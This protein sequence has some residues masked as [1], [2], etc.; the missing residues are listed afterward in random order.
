MKKPFQKAVLF[1]LC[2]LGVPA[3]LANEMDGDVLLI[4]YAVSSPTI[5]GAIDGVWKNVC[6]TFMRSYGNSGTLPE[7]RID[8]TGAFR[9]MWDDNNFYFLAYTQDDVLYDNHD[10]VW[11]NDGWELYFDADNSKGTSYD[12]VDDMQIRIEHRDQ[13]SADIDAGSWANKDNFVFANVDTLNGYMLELQ[14]PLAELKIPGEWGGEFG[15]EVQQNDN[16]GADREH[17]SKWWLLEGDRSWLDPSLF[18]T[19]R[20]VYFPIR[21][22]LIVG[23]PYIKPVIDGE[24]DEIWLQ[25][26]TLISMNSYT[27][28]PKIPDSFEDLEGSFR[29]MWDEDYLYGFFITRDDVLYD[30]HVNGWENDGW[31]LYFDADNSKGTSYDNVDDMQIRIEHRDQTS[32]DI[33]APSWVN[34]N[35]IVFVNKDHEDGKGYN[36]EVAIPLSEIQLT[37]PDFTIPG[38]ECKGFLEFGFE[39]Q[40]NDND[41]GD[42]EHISKWWLNHGDRSWLEPSLFGTAA[43]KL[44]ECPPPPVPDTTDA[45]K[46]KTMWAHGFALAQNYPNPFNLSTI[47]SYCLARSGKVRLAVYDLTGREVAL[48]VDWIQP[49]GVHEVLFHATHLTSGIYFYKLETSEGVLTQK[50]TVLK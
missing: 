37:L 34:K 30:N 14:I 44:R 33:D 15:F 45:V 43:L 29:L 24:L 47:I 31:E 5:D 42:R 11:E 50:L 4:P 39:A 46:G 8:L 19:A 17:I 18:G 32:A 41:G 27:N 40:Q 16:D 36:L 1:V 20:L 2:V 49:A 13:T 48:L 12:N 38:V 3:L 21:E 9:V 28:G 7:N 23:I 10:N 26:S 25:C 6:W 22:V 35:A